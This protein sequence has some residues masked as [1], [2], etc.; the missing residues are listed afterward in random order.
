MMAS[1]SPASIGDSAAPPGRRRQPG[2]WIP[3][4]F[5][6]LFM[7]VLA[8]NGVMIAIAVATFTGLETEN[9]YQKGLAYN[10]RLEAVAEQERLGWRAD[11]AATSGGGSQ[12]ELTLE[13]ADRLGAPIAS[14]EVE[15]RLVRPVQAGHDL[16]VRLEETDPGRYAAAV[17]LPLPGQW[18]VRLAAK[19]RDSAYRLTERIQAAP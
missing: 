9:A 17:D 18:D 4:L 6:G 1:A 15:A 12:V 7:I 5:I 14:A 11:F 10:D 8:A 16:T 13:L 19:A 3:W 2:H